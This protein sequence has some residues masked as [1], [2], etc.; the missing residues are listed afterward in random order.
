MGGSG[1]VKTIAQ[2]SI[3]LRCSLCLELVS[4]SLIT[5][6]LPLGLIPSSL[7]WDSSP[8]WMEALLPHGRAQ[9]PLLPHCS[10]QGKFSTCM[11]DSWPVAAVASIP[12]CKPHE[13]RNLVFPF[14]YSPSYPR[15]VPGTL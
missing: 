1:V 9:M 2:R 7:S 15:R 8:A 12:G 6:T 10:A 13:G 3:P 4:S 11:A 5:P 14:V